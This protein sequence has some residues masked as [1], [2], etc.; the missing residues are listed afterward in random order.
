MALTVSGIFARAWRRAPLSFMQ[1]LW[2]DTCWFALYLVM[3]AIND[4]VT[5]G[6]DHSTSVTLPLICATFVPTW[7][8]WT[9][10]P[11]LLVR[12]GARGVRF[13]AKYYSRGFTK[14]YRSWPSVTD[15]DRQVTAE[16]DDCGLTRAGIA[17][18]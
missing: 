13:L 11:A 4:E 15:L 16:S 3:L 9:L 6:S 17:R 18:M 2:R 8:F 12:D 14:S 7:V 5:F 10:T 1:R